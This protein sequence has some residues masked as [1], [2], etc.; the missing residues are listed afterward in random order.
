MMN[1][2]KSFKVKP[3]VNSRTNQI[4]ITLPRRQLG[5]ASNKKPRNMNVIIKSIRW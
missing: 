1:F 4:S 3:F 2:T 5:I